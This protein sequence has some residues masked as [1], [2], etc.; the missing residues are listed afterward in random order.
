MIGSLQIW[1]KFLVM[2]GAFGALLLCSGCGSDDG[3]FASVWNSAAMDPDAP[4]TPLPSAANSVGLVM[5]RLPP[6]QTVIGS[7]RSETC[8]QGDEGPQFIATFNTAF[9]ISATEVTQGQYSRVMKENPAACMDCGD[10]APVEGVTWNNAIHF[11]NTLSEKEGLAL[12]YSADGDETV[13]DFTADGY[14]LPTVV[15]WEYACRAGRPGPFWRGDDIKTCMGD[16]QILDELGWYAGNSGG[17]PHPVAQKLP[18]P[19]G[20]FD[21]HGNVWEWCWD[22]Y[23]VTKYRTHAKN[24]Y[25]PTGGKPVELRGGSWDAAPAGCR[26][27]RRLS[28]WPFQRTRVYGF[29]VARSAEDPVLP[30]MAQFQ[31][32]LPVSE[33]PAPQPPP[34]D[35]LP[36]DAP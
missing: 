5:V 20:L 29:R 36:A 1:G 22:K 35:Q 3:Q 16:S 7:P 15:E 12:C 8:R 2:A 6:G 34:V 31:T 4:Q 23:E 30:V 17:H 9:L 14:R 25:Q 32:G 11:C 21:M 27:A 28:D 24:G 33:A 13:C 19:W 26:A 18:N 10:D